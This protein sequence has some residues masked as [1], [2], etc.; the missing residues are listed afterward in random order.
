[1]ATKKTA[2]KKTVAKKAAAKKKTAAKK[3]AKKKTG[4]LKSITLKGDHTGGVKEIDGG[5][6][7]FTIMGGSHSLVA[8]KGGQKIRRIRIARNGADVSLTFEK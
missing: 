4:Q 3:T 6:H 1:M 7:T 8:P 2:V 5:S